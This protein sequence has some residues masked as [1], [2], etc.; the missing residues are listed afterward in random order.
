MGGVALGT[1]GLGGYDRYAAWGR[2]AARGLLA[3]LAGLLIASALVPLTVGRG[4][5][6]KPPAIV[7][8][9]AAL[10]ARPRA[11]HRPHAA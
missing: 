3:V 8:G 11:A 5:E 2:W 4:E 7:V 6:A 9:Q 1:F 10:K